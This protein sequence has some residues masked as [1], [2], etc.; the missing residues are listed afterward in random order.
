MK[1]KT[2]LTVL[3]LFVTSMMVG[4]GGGSSND[5]PTVGNQNKI[6]GKAVDGYLV[7]SI[8][9]LDL[10]L[11]NFCQ[12]ATEPTANTDNNGGYELT[13]TAAHKSHANF[14]VAPIVVY[15]GIDSDTN[16][17]FLGKLKALNDGSNIN[18]TSIT[19]LIEQHAKNTAGDG[20]APTQSQINDSI[21]KVKQALDLKEDADLTADPVQLKKDGDDSLMIAALGLQKSMQVLAKAKGQENNSKNKTEAEIIADMFKAMALAMNDLALTN[22]KG[23]E[24]LIAKAAAGSDS[25]KI[26]GSNAIAVKDTAVAIAAKVEDMFNGINHGNFEK[27]MKEVQNEIERDLIKLDQKIEAHNFSYDYDFNGDLMTWDQIKN[28]DENQLRSDAFEIEF[29]KVLG[30]GF[31]ATKLASVINALPVGFNSWDLFDS[32]DSLKDTGIPEFSTIQSAIE[33]VK[34]RWKLEEQNNL[35]KN[36]AEIRKI[37]LPYV[38][39]MPDIHMYPYSMCNTDSNS[40]ST[41]CCTTEY[42]L[43]AKY[44]EIS[45]QANK[46]I[47]NKRFEFEGS[48]WKEYVNQYDSYVQD[49]LV[50]FNQEW[51]SKATLT[52]SFTVQADNSIKLDN[53]NTLK[54]SKERAITTEYFED[55]DLNVTMPEGATK[56]WLTTTRDKTRYTLNYKMENYQN[57]NLESYS[58]LADFINQRCSENYTTTT[59]SCDGNNDSGTWIYDSTYSE[60]WT[61]QTIQG[62]EILIVEHVGYEDDGCGDIYAV[63]AGEVYQGWYTIA[64]TTKYPVYNKIAMD[65]IKSAIRTKYSNYSEQ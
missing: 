16:K 54:F 22:D 51:I 32:F 62:K 18:V 7:N 46:E 63:H 6:S 52:H 25:K 38:A 44:S 4:C 2:K 12:V 40:N 56:S 28:Q 26:M 21:A 8:V 13:L 61:K 58:S 9:C 55:L 53:F 48:D 19:T 1:N 39:Y 11:D 31:D 14:K 3:I 42:E 60:K 59:V 35:D 45:L 5:N 65:A 17:R 64:E 23:I 47:S 15:D 43:D 20:K 41:T 36:S 49:D 50:L 57:G 10:N 37:T 24:K 27:E 33:R 34:T 30:L 29:N